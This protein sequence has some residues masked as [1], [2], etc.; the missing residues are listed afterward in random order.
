M[1]PS[2]RCFIKFYNQCLIV[3]G[4]FGDEISQASHGFAT[5]TC[6]A[7]VAEISGCDD[8]TA[9]MLPNRWKYCTCGFASSVDRNICCKQLFD[10]AHMIVSSRSFCL[11]DRDGN[12]LICTV[13]VADFANHSTNPNT[14][15][16]LSSL[17]CRD[18]GGFCASHVLQTRRPVTIGEEVLLN[19]GINKSN[20][21][22]LSCYGFCLP[23]NLADR[24]PLGQRGTWGDHNDIL[25]DLK[26]VDE[27]MRRVLSEL[28]PNFSHVF[29]G[30]SQ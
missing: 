18:H 6:G 23:G 29:S 25:E 9:Y 20:V 30:M 24:L 19:Y 13:P 8:S 27:L 11:S 17:P 14:S 12:R 15:F 22:L 26:Y 7:W 2:N 28:N 10:W 4:S 16:V 5:N 21:L 3:I 1:E